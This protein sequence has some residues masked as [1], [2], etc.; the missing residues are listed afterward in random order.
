MDHALQVCSLRMARE[1]GVTGP[2]R[3][4]LRL[5][6]VENITS[7]GA[8]ASRLVLHK[9]TVTGIVS[10]LEER[11]LV[12]RSADSGD[13]RRQR[14]ALT[15]AGRRVARPHPGTIEAAVERA[16]TTVRAGEVKQAGAFLERLAA[17]LLDAGPKTRRPRTASARG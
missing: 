8:L 9:S 12:V 15:A 1:H 2:Q 10:R 11:G 3:L 7:P 6:A 17:E 5:M 4:A 13:G 16:L 14:L